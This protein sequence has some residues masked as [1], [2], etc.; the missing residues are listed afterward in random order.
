M[1][2]TPLNRTFTNWSD[3][4]PEFIAYYNITVQ[5]VDNVGGGATDW[6]YS[7]YGVGFEI[8][9]KFIY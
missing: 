4:E 3:I 1:S 6:S 7:V 2:D 5:T 8:L 9:F